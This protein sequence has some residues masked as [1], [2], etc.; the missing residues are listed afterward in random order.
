LK[1]AGDYESS[2][3][4]NSNL[5]VERRKLG[6]V[7]KD[8]RDRSWIEIFGDDIEVRYEEVGLSKKYSEYTPALRIVKK[9]RVGETVEWKMLLSE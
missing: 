7:F 9:L 4:L 1:G 8:P 5:L 6:L 3:M 2:L